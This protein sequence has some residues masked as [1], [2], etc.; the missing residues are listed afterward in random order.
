MDDAADLVVRY[1]SG[2]A[3][4]ADVSA[5][6]EWVLQSR[7]HRN[8]FLALKRAWVL[9][10]LD[11]AGPDIEID[12]EWAELQDKLSDAVPVVTLPSKKPVPNWQWL[13]I[14]AAIALIAVLSIWL[15]NTAD[16]PTLNEIV[17]SE[18]SMVHI[19][20]DG[21]KIDLNR[22]ASL[23]YFTDPKGSERRV[24]LDGDAFFEIARDTTRP[25]IISTQ[26]MEIEVLG[27]SFYVDS[28]EAEA[29][30]QVMVQSGSVSLR[31]NTDQIILS[32]GETGIYD[33]AN[34]RLIK[35][36]TRDPNFLS[37]K[38][39]RLIFNENDL[40]QVVFALNRH[41]QSNV[42]LGN[43]ELS[44]CKLTATYDGQ[45]L[46]AVIRILEKTLN[47]RAE[48]SEGKIFFRGSGCNE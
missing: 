31:H 13:K 14:A 23:K 4:Q 22:Q 35:E 10:N 19:L 26:Q 25:F 18:T 40:D 12:Q 20:A 41:F 17:A 3:S 30:I 44:L 43:P 15:L 11:H 48:E 5:L 36:P 32:P 42:V 16:R 37:W 38:S 9:S 28:R 2:N 33:K 6:E 24:T 46:Q 21:S 1:L 39:N 34:N 27:T 47:I 45:S 29:S 7:D 8:Q